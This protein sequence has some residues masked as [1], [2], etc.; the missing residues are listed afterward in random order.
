M[1]CQ[2]KWPSRSTQLERLRERRAAAELLASADPWLPLSPLGEV[3]DEQFLA[4]LERLGT[5]WNEELTK[6]E[7]GPSA[8]GRRSHDA[9]HELIIGLIWTYQRITR[10][11]ARKPSTRFNK[12]GYYGDFYR[13]AIAAW[14]CL[15]DRVPETRQLMPYSEAALGEA[16][17]KHWPKKGTAAHKVIGTQ[18]A[19]WGI[20]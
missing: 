20:N 8:A 1:D 4:T 2:N 10:K 12:P 3:E 11:P 19:R 6:L 18:A 7:A 16:L 5:F 9:F 15:W 14:R 13:F 17:R